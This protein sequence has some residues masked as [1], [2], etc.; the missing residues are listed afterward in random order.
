M[1]GSHF[2]LVPLLKTLLMGYVCM[3]IFLLFVLFLEFNE[4]GKE[5][6]TAAAVMPKDSAGNLPRDSLP[7]APTP[8]KDDLQVPPI[9]RRRKVRGFA[10]NA[11]YTAAIHRILSLH[12]VAVSMESTATTKQE[13]QQ[14]QQQQQQ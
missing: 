4:L 2:L 11:S 10:E 7:A 6:G 12:A 5:L 3:L 9:G 14:Q 8:G 1:P 13:Q